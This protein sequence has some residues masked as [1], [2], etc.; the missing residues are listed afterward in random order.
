MPA[1]LRKSKNNMIT[2]IK[3]SRSPF[4]WLSLGVTWML[5]GC[6]LFKYP[7]S[8]PPDAYTRGVNYYRDG[9]YKS[10][11]KELG[12]LPSKDPKFNQA[13]DYLKKANDR[14]L[15]A[16]T[17]VN[18]ALEYRNL[19]ELFKAKKELEGTL[20]VYP[21]HRKAQMLLDALDLDIEAT[22]DFY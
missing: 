14:I 18:A 15:E 1:L 16:S 20:E 4:L 2:T 7:L 22:V 17:H 5:I 12:S 19:G 3:A 8:N 9:L 13:Q 6:G 10:A 11:A 21:K